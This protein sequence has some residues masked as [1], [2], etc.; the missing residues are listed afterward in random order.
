MT[1]QTESKPL[2]ISE[3][4]RLGEEKNNLKIVPLKMERRKGNND[5]T[6]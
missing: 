3:L 2:S 6:D 1:E 4:I 5:R